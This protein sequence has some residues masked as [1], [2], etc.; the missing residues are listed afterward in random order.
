MPKAH[1]T[2]DWAAPT[3]SRGQLAYAAADAVLTAGACGRRRAREL[4]AKSRDLRPIGCSG[5][6]FPPPRRWS[7][8]AS[9][10]TSMRMPSSV[11][12]VVPR[13]CRR[14]PGLGRGDGHAAA[15]QAGGRGSVPGE[16][17]AGGGS[18]RAGRAPAPARLSTAAD[19]LAKVAHLPAIR[20]LL[21]IKKAE[22]LLSAFGPKLRRLINPETGRLHPHYNVAVDQGRP[23]ERVRPEH[24]AAAARRRDPPHHRRRARPRAGRRRLQPDGTSGRRLD[25]RRCRAD[26]RPTSRASTCTCSPPPRSTASSPRR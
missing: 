14:A 7:F 16:G 8:A 21:R 5:T 15:E 12:Q 6:V 25:Q 13:S 10:S 17:S 3:L 22:K 1:Q 9:P 20:P 26:A 11:R 2:S 23:L 4:K 24:P 18:S 19:Q